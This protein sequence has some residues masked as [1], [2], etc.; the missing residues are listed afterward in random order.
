MAWL[1]PPE[2]LSFRSFFLTS[3]NQSRNA[4]VKFWP[5][6]SNSSN[7]IIT[8]RAFKMLSKQ[9]IEPIIFKVKF[10]KDGG[11]SLN[12]KTNMGENGVS[13]ISSQKSALV[14]F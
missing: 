11:K 4:P 12:L 5:L 10:A 7:Y 3:V 6:S 1:N 9:R 13:D 2:Y 14:Q 8:S